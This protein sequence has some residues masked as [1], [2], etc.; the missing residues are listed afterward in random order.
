M[1]TIETSVWR[2][3]GKLGRNVMLRS[4]IR[5][6]GQAWGNIIML[7]AATVV[8]NARAMKTESELVPLPFHALVVAVAAG[9]VWTS[10]HACVAWLGCAQNTFGI[11]QV[12]FRCCTASHWKRT[13]VLD[14]SVL[15]FEYNRIT[16]LTYRC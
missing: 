12:H 15:L 8:V 4:Q 10:N 16:L 5:F 9:D 14:S 7:D 1:E 11:V 13:V 6:Q 3:Q 2:S